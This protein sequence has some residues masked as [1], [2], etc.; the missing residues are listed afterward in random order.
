MLRPSLALLTGLMAVS[1]QAQFV[2]PKPD[3]HEHLQNVYKEDPFIVEYRRKFFSVFRG[4]LATF[5]KA[6]GEIQE[7]VKR[8]PNDAR[9]A[10]WLGNG[11]TIEAMLLFQAGQPDKAKHLLATSRDTVN[12]AV[13]L[14]PNDPNIFMM[15]E[16]TLY[17][18]GQ[19]LPSM[20][21]PESNWRI[22]RTDCRHFLSYVGPSRVPKLSV[23]VRGEAYG[24]L[25]I[26][27]I[28]LGLKDE[29]KD[30]FRHVIAL[31]P[32]SAYS[33][34]AERELAALQATG[35]RQR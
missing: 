27:C 11:Q 12:H 3:E 4:D 30:A 1:V 29:A 24:E 7:Q 21:V 2:W 15:R 5:R 35:A 17:V 20:L 32:N 9:A 14:R 16:V 22:I 26:A 28:K 6:Y 18:Q 10:V 34:R 25:G 23:H 31:N 33:K 19:Y 13:A 8:N